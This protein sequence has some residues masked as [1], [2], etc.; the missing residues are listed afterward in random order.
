[1]LLVIGIIIIILDCFIDE[2]HFKIVAF[3]FILGFGCAV[4]ALFLAFTRPVEL[5]YR[6]NILSL[7]VF[8]GVEGHFRIGTGHVNS[9]PV[10]YFYTK[11]NGMYKIESVTGNVQIKL[12]KDNHYIECYC[13]KPDFWIPSGS[14]KMTYYIITIPEN[15]IVSENFDPNIK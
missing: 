10:Y 9:E 11:N 12:D 2:K 15:S 4:S 14:D 7:N 8:N 1:M 3:L 5:A 6:K 13:Q